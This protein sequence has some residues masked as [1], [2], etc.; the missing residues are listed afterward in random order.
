MFCMQGQI[1]T[2]WLRPAARQEKVRHWECPAWPAIETSRPMKASCEYF[3]RYHYRNHIREASPDLMIRYT[4]KLQ[5]SQPRHRGR[6]QAP[7]RAPQ[8]QPV[9]LWRPAATAARRGGACLFNSPVTDDSVPPRSYCTLNLHVCG[10]E[11]CSHFAFLRASTFIVL[12]V[13][14]QRHRAP[15]EDGPLPPPPARGGALPGFVSAADAA[16]LPK[17]ARP[18]ESETDEE[19]KKREKREKKVRAA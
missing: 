12:V 2:R 16:S 17:A 14:L 5:I 4:V 19:R 15:D 11:R 9:P 13:I 7:T 1:R 3:W 10:V 6:A 18:V 8:P